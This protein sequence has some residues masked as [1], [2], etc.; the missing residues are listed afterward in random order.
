MGPKPV[1]TVLS[2]EEE[3][4]AVAVRQHMY[5]RSMTASMPSRKPFFT[6]DPAQLTLG[7]YS[8]RRF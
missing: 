4:I 7:L 3:A 2:V 8:K 1:S 5:C 6:R